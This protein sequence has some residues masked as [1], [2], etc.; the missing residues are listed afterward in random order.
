MPTSSPL[1]YVRVFCDADGKGDTRGDERWA[2]GIGNRGEGGTRSLRLRGFGERHSHSS[3]RNAA[4]GAYLEVIG[5]LQAAASGCAGRARVSQRRFH[6]QRV[7]PLPHGS[8]LE[9]VGTRG[10]ICDVPSLPP[11]TRATKLAPRQSDAETVRGR[12][13]HP[14][15]SRAPGATPAPS[16]NIRVK[17]A[18]KSTLR[19]HARAFPSRVLTSA[20]GCT[21][22]RTSDAS[23]APPPATPGIED[24]IPIRRRPRR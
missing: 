16:T 18:L 19:A 23:P 21:P 8:S 9:R 20:S 15:V 11:R 14:S 6:A 2:K 1:V 5:P 12:T 22:P 4:R 10:E 7:V 3:R 13:F 24:L 17:D